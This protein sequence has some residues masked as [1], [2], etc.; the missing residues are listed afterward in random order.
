MLAE[1]AHVI[2]SNLT[3]FFSAP[4]PPNNKNPVQFPPTL[5]LVTRA[6][7]TPA[8]AQLALT[9]R[10]RTLS[11]PRHQGAPASLVSMEMDSP[12][13]VTWSPPNTIGLYST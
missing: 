7:P 12:A 1:I 8:A 11:P 4:P 9:A 5:T 3:C 6:T 10:S 2:A 13:H